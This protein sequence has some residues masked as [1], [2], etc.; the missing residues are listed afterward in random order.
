VLAAFADAAWSSTCLDNPLAPFLYGVST[1]HCMS[2]GRRRSRDV[3]GEQLARDMLAEAGYVDVSVRDVLD[4]P[5]N[6]VYVSRTAT[7]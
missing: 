3:W 4:D 2:P 5:L 1:L 7:A 6:Q